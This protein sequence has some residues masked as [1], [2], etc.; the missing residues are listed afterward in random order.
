MGFVTKQLDAVEIE[1]ESD[2]DITTDTQIRLNTP[3][4]LINYVP[5]EQ[6]V[7]N[8]V[9][10]EN[11][12][13]VHDRTTANIRSTSSSEVD[14]SDAFNSQS[15]YSGDEVTC[16]GV[17]AKESHVHNRA[18]CVTLTARDT[19][20]LDNQTNPLD[21]THNVNTLEDYVYSIVNQ[22]T[23][24]ARTPTQRSF[25]SDPLIALPRQSTRQVSDLGTF[26][27]NKLYTTKVNIIDAVV[28]L[29]KDGSVQRP[30]TII[31]S[32]SAVNLNIS[33][34]VPTTNAS[35]NRTVGESIL[36]GNSVNLK[37]YIYEQLN[38]NGFFDFFTDVRN[39]VDITMEYI[40]TDSRGGF[41]NRE[42]GDH[43]RYRIRFDMYDEKGFE[44]ERIDYINPTTIKTE[45]E[46]RDG[47]YNNSPIIFDGLTAGN[48]YR[49]YA[50]VTNLHTNTTV[51]NI[52]PLHE[53]VATIPHIDVSSTNITF[54]FENDHEMIIEFNNHA[55]TIPG[56]PLIHFQIE[57]VSPT[58]SDDDFYYLDDAS[59]INPT[60]NTA[61][62]QTET[63]FTIPFR[64]LPQRYL[65]STNY[66]A[67]AVD[68][69]SYTRDIESTTYTILSLDDANCFRYINTA[70]NHRFRIRSYHDDGVSTF[71]MKSSEFGIY[72]EESLLDTLKALSVT[73][74]GA[75]SVSHSLDG[76]NNVYTFTVNIEAT[77]ASDKYTYLQYE[78]QYKSSLAESYAIKTMSDI[79]IVSDYYHNTATTANLVYT[80]ASTIDAGYYSII[81]RNVFGTESTNSTALNI[82]DYTI[83]DPTYERN[84]SKS[85]II[86]WDYTDQQYPITS[87][88]IR[89]D[90]DTSVISSS[91]VGR[92]TA[93]K[94]TSTYFDNTHHIE[95]AQDTSYEFTVR[96]VD[97][98][99][100][101]KD[102]IATTIVINTISNFTY[103][104]ASVGANRIITVNFK[105]NNI[106]SFNV[107]YGWGTA[108]TVT[109][110][111]TGTSAVEADP[112]KT[113]RITIDDDSVQ[114]FTF[115]ATDFTADGTTTSKSYSA[116]VPITDYMTFTQDILLTPITVTITA[117][118]SVKIVWDGTTDSRK[119]KLKMHSFASGTSAA[120]YSI[121]SQT[122]TLT[123]T[124]TGITFSDDS[125]SSTDADITVGSSTL[126][127]PND[128][129]LSVDSSVQNSTGFSLSRD[130]SFDL[131]NS[132]LND[133]GDA[134]LSQADLVTSVTIT[135]GNEI[136]GTSVYDNTAVTNTTTFVSAVWENDSD[137]VISDEEDATITLSNKY[138]IENG[139][140]NV[141]VKCTIT[142]RNVV[143]FSKTLSQQTKMV[144]GS[145]RR[146]NFGTNNETHGFTGFTIDST[147]AFTSLSYLANIIEDGSN[148]DS[149]NLD[150]DKYY[151]EIYGYTELNG[152]GS[153]TLIYEGNAF[154]S[155][156]DVT[157]IAG[158]YLSDYLS[159]KLSARLIDTYGFLRN[160]L[161]TFQKVANIVTP[162]DTEELTHLTYPT[163][164]QIGT[165]Y[166]S[167]ET[168][169]DNLSDGQSPT[170][171]TYYLRISGSSSVDGSGLLQVSP[172][173]ITLTSS[174]L[175]SVITINA[176]FIARD[177]SSS[178]ALTQGN[179]Y[180]CQI[181]RSFSGGWNYNDSVSD[182]ISQT[183][184]TPPTL[185]ADFEMGHTFVNTNAWEI[186]FRNLTFNYNAA[187]RRYN[188]QFDT[189]L[190]F[191]YRAGRS[192]NFRS[193][194][195]AAS[196]FTDVT[197]SNPDGSYDSYGWF[198]RS[199]QKAFI[200]EAN[201]ASVLGTTAPNNYE[202]AMPNIATMTFNNVRSWLR[203]PIGTNAYIYQ[204]NFGHI[205]YS[206]APGRTSEK[207]QGEDLYWHAILKI[208]LTEYGYSTTYFG[209]QLTFKARADIGTKILFKHPISSTIYKSGNNV[210]LTLNEI[211]TNGSF[212]AS[213]SEYPWI[214]RF[215]KGNVIPSRDIQSLHIAI[216]SQITYLKSEVFYF[217]TNDDTI[218]V[219]EGYDANLI[220]FSGDISTKATNEQV[221]ITSS[222]NS[223]TTHYAFFIIVFNA[224]TYENNRRAKNVTVDYDTVPTFSDNRLLSIDN[225]AN[226]YNNPVFEFQVS[227]FSLSTTT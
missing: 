91:S 105:A 219:A 51:K 28:S 195:E 38:E 85:V 204:F 46:A 134:S 201:M 62:G 43:F 8:I 123:S 128:V 188:S 49:I 95:F 52:G 193:L 155:G 22:G 100:R 77:F 96:A 179:T 89:D 177:A 47:V 206:D 72:S 21:I 40:D 137:T 87:W 80:S 167:V 144:K 45:N 12:T 18:H 176:D 3:Q 103:I 174:D 136:P 79:D 34:Y 39:G 215:S 67:Q 182:P 190:Y 138:L 164:S 200:R 68:I 197:Y 133:F 142:V 110:D 23:T 139:H 223:N 73:T 5:L 171:S 20:R 82:K 104:S 181:Y 121:N 199:N 140:D 66:V 196:T 159:F 194:V 59:G 221:D 150:S 57:L 112:T 173:T 11:I 122:W 63:T 76:S 117:F 30:P 172:T 78:L 19:L 74:T 205:R 9:F 14:L 214:Q 53:N 153:S 157:P 25:T 71:E 216:T 198:F 218:K 90:E 148:E 129:V 29:N 6:Y 210:A 75:P 168:N 151:F 2:L 111:G 36:F 156:S 169:N 88:S 184:L 27:T 132:A 203:N 7:R 65:N 16:L 10:D 145:I 178:L 217:D 84:D 225:I 108:P 135:A 1:S 175:N 69:V 106:N 154:N 227:E 185:S 44:P 189:T 141:L 81:V 64:Y 143:G 86:S 211:T 152:G 209:P 116:S 149:T 101:V 83:D 32:D 187:S 54:T 35:V 70:Q 102:S 125:T 222:L 93:D 58:V 166:F 120:D 99:G 202:S 183:L 50:N 186:F 26:H 92:T 41:H 4:L 224:P 161:Q 192:T 15:S 24:N 113:H 115:K 109:T 48:F 118:P 94:S 147:S 42:Y 213:H 165:T 146:H 208:T 126:T 191:Q 158:T 162:E 160:Y 97:S 114:T 163:S 207:S 31:E 119:F 61:N 130:Y 60:Q 33:T 37:K 131:D 56:F 170:S 180:H 107:K 212:S 124:D 220:S 98:L 55:V 127:L 13:T 226:D 17:S